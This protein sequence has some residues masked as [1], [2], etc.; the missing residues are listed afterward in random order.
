MNEYA[1]KKGILRHNFRQCDLIS[2]ATLLN[3]KINYY[4]SNRKLWRYPLEE[5]QICVGLYDNHYF[6]IKK[7]DQ[8]TECYRYVVKNL[9]WTDKKLSSATTEIK[10]QNIKYYECE[11]KNIYDNH[12][13]FDLETFKNW[14]LWFEPFAC[15]YTSMQAIVKDFN[16]RNYVQ[17]KTGKNCIMEMLMN[18]D[19]ITKKT[20]LELESK[21]K[22]KNL[23]FKPKK[24]TVV[25]KTDVF[26]F[27]HN[28]ACFDS[29]FFLQLEKCKVKKMVQ[30]GGLMTITITSDEFKNAN[31]IIKDTFK[32]L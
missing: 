12:Y 31:F 4:R 15:G 17:I 29:Y 26:L 24:F 22:D 2:I 32:F 21:P 28:S 9:V 1:N 16:K 18:I 8:P 19:A 20:K 6:L 14:D 10:E 23:P 5:N 25:N 30:K 3:C 27:A 13:K 11:D 7:T